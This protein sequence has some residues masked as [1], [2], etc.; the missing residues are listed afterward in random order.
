MSLS[1][2]QFLP[3]SKDSRTQEPRL[4]DRVVTIDCAG[5][6]RDEIEKVHRLLDRSRHAFKVTE[7][8]SSQTESV[9]GS[10]SFL[11]LETRLTISFSLKL[12]RTQRGA[13]DAIVKAVDETLSESAHEQNREPRVLYGS[14]GE[15]VVKIQEST[16][17]R[18]KKQSWSKTD[19]LTAAGIVLAS[20]IGVS[21][22]FV[23]EVRQFFHLEKKPKPIETQTTLVKSEQAPV[24]PNPEESKPEPNKSKKPLNTQQAAA[25]HIKGNG[26]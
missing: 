4:D 19:K 10:I 3:M 26:N 15:I 11:Q 18:S 25:A 9:G 16:R 12:F 20:L 14:N 23:P 7:V 5:L 1:P 8:A 22:F 24:I 21:A 2:V 17:P 6:Y 13:V